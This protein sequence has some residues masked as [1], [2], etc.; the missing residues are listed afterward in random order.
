MQHEQTSSY[1]LRCAFHN[2]KSMEFLCEARDEHNQVSVYLLLELPPHVLPG[3]FCMI[4]NLHLQ[5][6]LHVCNSVTGDTW[7][8]NN[9]CFKH[10]WEVP[11]SV[12]ML[13]LK[14]FMGFI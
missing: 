14:R 11:V 7:M 9:S 5:L 4:T 1:A 8:N 10:H 12:G 6:R 2:H 13:L 3:E